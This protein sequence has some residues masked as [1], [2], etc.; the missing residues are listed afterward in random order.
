M[1]A[2]EYTYYLWLSTAHAEWYANHVVSFRY[3]EHDGSVVK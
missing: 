1:R 3:I 2:I